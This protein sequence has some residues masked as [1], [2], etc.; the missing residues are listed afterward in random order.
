MRTDHTDGS[1][2]AQRSG[3]SPA[4]LARRSAGTIAGVG[5]RGLSATHPPSC[6]PWL[7]GRYPAST[8]TMGALTPVRHSSPHRSPCLTCTAFLTIPPPTTWCL[9]RRRFRTLPLSA[10]GL[11]PSHLRWRVKASP[12]PSGLAKASGR[13]EFVILRT[14]R[15]PP[16]ASH[17]ASRRRSR[18]WLQAGERMPGEDFHLSDHARSQAH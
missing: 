2:Q 6:T 14:G 12:F 10:T 18:S 8:L 13:I 9:P 15:S 17:P 11:P 1:V 5:S 16:A 7:H 4:C 3:P